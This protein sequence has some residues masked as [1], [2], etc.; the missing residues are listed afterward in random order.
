MGKKNPYLKESDWGWAIDPKGL[1]FFL[2]EIYDRY[3]IPLMNCE[4]GLGA[5]RRGGRR[6]PCPPPRSAVFQQLPVGRLSDV[7]VLRANS[8]KKTVTV[9]WKKVKGATGYVVYRATK[10]N[11]KYKAVKTIKKASTTKFKNKKLKK[12]KTYYYKVRAIKSRKES[13]IQ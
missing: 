1:K 4:N 12:K 10:K 8:S 6:S 9:T 7:Q 13:N 3:Q 11:G 2:H 5:V